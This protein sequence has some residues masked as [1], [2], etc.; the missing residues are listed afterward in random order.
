MAFSIM[1]AR[2]LQEIKKNEPINIIQL[3]KKLKTSGGTSIYRYLRELEKRGLIK[4]YKEEKKRGQPTLLITTE[5][6]KPLLEGEL[7]A[8]DKITGYFK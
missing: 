3:T 6:A 4:T 5:K 1:R 7:K 2:I 8:L